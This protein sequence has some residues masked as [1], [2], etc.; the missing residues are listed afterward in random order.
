M[1][2]YAHALVHIPGGQFS[3]IC[4][5]FPQCKPSTEPGCEAWQQCP[6]PLSHLSSPALV[7]LNRENLWWKTIMGQDTEYK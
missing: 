4:F 3:R 7:I 2:T 6:L 5:H 1:R